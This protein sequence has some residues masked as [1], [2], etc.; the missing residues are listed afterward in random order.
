[1]GLA[2]ELLASAVDALVDFPAVLGPAQ[3]DGCYLIGA[4]RPLG[5]LAAEVVGDA[6]PLPFL[7]RALDRL[8]PEWRELPELRT[9]E[10]GDDARAAGLLS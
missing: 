2:P 9:I 8:A 6:A 10:T 1:M 5:G 3:H 4:R 7:R